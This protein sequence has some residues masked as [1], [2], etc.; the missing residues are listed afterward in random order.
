MFNFQKKSVDFVKSLE[1]TTK[2]RKEY[3]RTYIDNEK[4]QFSLKKYL[5]KG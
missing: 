2:K 5:R 1:N 4:Y 3:V